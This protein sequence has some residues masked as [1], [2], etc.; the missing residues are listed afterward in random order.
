MLIVCNGAFK[1]GSTWLFRIAKLIILSKPIP[2]EFHSFEKWHGQS[3]AS[4]KLSEFLEKVDYKNENYVCKS[5]YDDV[6]IRELLLSFNGVYILNIKR[7]IRDVIVSAYYHYN[8]EDGVKRTFEEF[9]WEKGQSLIRFINQYHDIWQNING[10]IYVSSYQKLHEDF[11]NEVRRIFNFLNY[12]L[13]PNDLELLREKTSLE[14]S[15]KLWKEDSKP[16]DERFFRKGVIG[17]WK[18]HFTPLIEKDFIK[19]NQALES[20]TSI[21]KKASFSIRKRMYGLKKRF[22]K[23]RVAPAAQDATMS[24]DK[25]RVGGKICFFCKFLQGISKKRRMD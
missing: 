9:Y 23:K 13:K 19:I 14:T 12:N 3:I 21:S 2:S 16:P 22:S 5:H 4:D 1:S 7:D 20:T 8:K 25:S 17:D 10:K 18:S 6:N 24:T 15:R 11:D